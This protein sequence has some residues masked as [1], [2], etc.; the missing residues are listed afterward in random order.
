M[1]RDGSLWGRELPAGPYSGASPSMMSPSAPSPVASHPDLPSRK[2]GWDAVRPRQSWLV[3]LFQVRLNNRRC[4]AGADQPAN[5]S[6]VA[7]VGT[8]GAEEQPNAAD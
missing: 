6:I 8:L 3:G 2:R 5:L 7:E 1:G 4:Q